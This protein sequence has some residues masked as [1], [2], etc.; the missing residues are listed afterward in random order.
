MRKEGKKNLKYTRKKNEWKIL[1]ERKI[2]SFKEKE[3]TKES[4][5]ISFKIYIKSIFDKKT[6]ER[7][8]IL[9]KSNFE[10]KWI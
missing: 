7:N 4:I 1:S 9:L 8:W 10:R 5:K 6:E 3:R 2:K